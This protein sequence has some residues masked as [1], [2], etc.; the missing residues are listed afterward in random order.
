ME[1]L[2]RTSP[3]FTSNCT[4]P[5]LNVVFVIIFPF[6]SMLNHISDLEGH[7]QASFGIESRITGG[8][9]P[10]VKFFTDNISGAAHTFGYVFTGHFKMN[11]SQNRSFG[12][13]NFKKPGNLRENIIKIPGL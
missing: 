6:S 3:V 8:I 4:A 9:I 5:A 2:S 1:R 10:I 7:L 13:D 12:P 11:A